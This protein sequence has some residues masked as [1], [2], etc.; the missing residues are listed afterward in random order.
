V[1]DSSL[2]KLALRLQT[3]R[4]DGIPDGTVFLLIVGSL[5]NQHKQAGVQKWVNA[6]LGEALGEIKVLS[7]FLGMRND[8]LDC[9]GSVNV[10]T[11]YAYLFLEGVHS[12]VT[13]HPT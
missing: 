9:I 10:K 1:T 11:R 12:P 4:L 13:Q 6:V 7:G 8:V 2:N 5:F 3:R